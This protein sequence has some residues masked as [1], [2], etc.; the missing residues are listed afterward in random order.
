MAGFTWT[1]TTSGDW[2][3]ATNWSPATVPNASDADVSI[4]T[5]GTYTVTIAAGASDAV[6]SVALDSAAGTLEVDGTLDFSGGP[7]DITGPLE[8]VLTMNDGTIVNGG[9]MNPN[10]VVNSGTAV[11]TGTNGIYFG[12]GLTATAATTAVVS[13][14]GGLA[15]YDTPTNTLFDGIFNANDG[16]IDI[17][18]TLDGASGV[19][20][21]IQTLEGP[22]VNPAFVTEIILMGSSAAVNEWNGTKYVPVESTLTTITS[23]GTVFTLNHDYTT[24]NA[25]TV[26]AG[27]LMFVSSGSLSATGGVTVNSGGTLEGSSASFGSSIVD[28]GTVVAAGGVLLLQGSISGSGVLTYDPTSTAT[29]EIAG[30][31]GNA[32]SM[33]GTATLQLDA[34]STFTGTVSAGGG[35]TIILQGITA[36]SAVLNGSTLSVQNNGTQVY[37][38]ATSGLTGDTF[39]VSTAAGAATIDIVCFARGARIR[40]PDGDVPVEELA[41]GQDVVTASGET[42]AIKWI[43]RRRV[44]CRRHPQPWRVWPIRISA[45]AFGNGLPRR[46]LLVS[47][48]HAIFDHGVLVPA[49]FLINDTTIVQEPVGHVE[50]FHVELP[51]HDL[52]LAEG[53]P[54]ESYLENGDRNSFENG[55]G[56][57]LLHPD[58]S[59]WS[60]DARACAELKVT[61][62]EL[63][64]IRAKLARRAARQRRASA[65]GR[66]A[67][68]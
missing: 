37:A 23:R 62:P 65:A 1:S 45:G 40:T 5:P 29:I 22:P 59:R 63:Q 58:F 56:P 3:T 54:T 66:S 33:V 20:F 8:A 31:T 9:T 47:P 55:G 38:L 51:K 16:T 14:S 19:A 44:D 36:D 2:N 32:V 53:L 35:D 6:H 10:F 30:A 52:L 4:T 17:G 50:Y 39:S 15:E 43:G 41:V 27:G 21:N 13:P 11:F 26:G 12:N 57:M 18:G 42:V 64:A 34:P 68:V 61:G 60:W 28:N 48:Q 49:R 25:L 7:G 24:T 67:A 46:D